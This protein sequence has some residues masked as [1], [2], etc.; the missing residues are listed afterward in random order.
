MTSFVGRLDGEGTMTEYGRLGG[1]RGGQP[2]D[3]TD[4]FAMAIKRC[5]G[6]A[7]KNDDVA[8]ELWSALANQGWHHEG[9]DT[10]AYSFRAAGDLIAAVRGEGSYLD[11]YCCGPDGVVSKRIAATLAQEG[12]YPDDE[13]GPPGFR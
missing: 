3:Q 11:W 5:V 7:L 12:W 4:A 1:I 10:A 6:D 8:V 2:F 9:G 13:D